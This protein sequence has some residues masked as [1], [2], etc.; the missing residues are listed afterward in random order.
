MLA[1]IDAGFSFGEIFILILFVEIGE[2]E[3]LDE[4]LALIAEALEEGAF[5]HAGPI[6]EFTR[7]DAGAELEEGLAQRF[8][9]GFVV[10]STR[11]GQSE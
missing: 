8:E 11:A 5:A 10:D 1:K 4:H 3:R 6:G 2:A 9:Q 7:G